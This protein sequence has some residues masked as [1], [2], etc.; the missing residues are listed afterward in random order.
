MKLPQQ[1]VCAI[2]LSKTGILTVTRKHTTLLSL[3]GGKVDKGETL[4]EALV[5]EL[6]EET[7]LL[8]NDQLFT[9]VL[10]QLVIGDDGND[11]YTTCFYY[12]TLQTD[13]LELLNRPWIVEEGIECKFTSINKLITEGVFSDYNN[14]AIVAVGKLFTRS[15]TCKK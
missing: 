9:P 8:F 3:P 4:T 7:G 10:G 1:A 5:R 2:V 12:Y 14:K 13:E 6:Y 11:Y 15:I